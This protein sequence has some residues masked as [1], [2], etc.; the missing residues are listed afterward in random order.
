MYLIGIDLGASACKTVIFSLEGRKIS[1]AQR[2]YPV[3]EGQ[4]KRL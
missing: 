1:E 3:L 2:E 4:L